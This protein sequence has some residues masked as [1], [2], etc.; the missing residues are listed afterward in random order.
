MTPGMATII[1]VPAAN[2]NVTDSVCIS[3]VAKALAVGSMSE[4]WLPTTKL[5]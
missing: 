5:T 2:A 4:P 1:E 3:V